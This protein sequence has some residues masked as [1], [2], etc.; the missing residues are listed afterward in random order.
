[1]APLTKKPTRTSTKAA[2]INAFGPLMGQ[3][4]MQLRQTDA[5]RPGEEKAQSGQREIRTQAVDDAEVDT[6]LESRL[7]LDD[8]RSQPVGRRPHELEEHEQVE[9]VASEGEADHARK[10]Q[11]HE[12]VIMGFDG[13]KIANAVEESDRHQAAGQQLRFPRPSGSTT[14]T[15][16]TLYPWCG[17]H[18]AAQLTMRPSAD[19]AKR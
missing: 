14:N 9:E 10:E 2:R 5:P 18:P 19:V 3:R 17:D 12:A 15:I 4:V 11:Q 8:D 13:V 7:V 6:T 1:M 16:P